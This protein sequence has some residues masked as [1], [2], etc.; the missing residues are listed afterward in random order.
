ADIWMMDLAR[1]GG[2]SEMR[3]V[4]ALAGAHD[5]PVSNHVFTEHSLAACSTFSNLNFVEYIYWFEALF[6]EPARMID[7]FLEVPTAPGLGFSFDQ[8]RIERYRVK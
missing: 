4:A 2:L 1:V 3:K 6:V 7:G 5:I 8:K